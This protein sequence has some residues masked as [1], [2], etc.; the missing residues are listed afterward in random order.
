MKS[1]SLAWL[2]GATSRSGGLLLILGGSVARYQST[3]H[4]CAIWPPFSSPHPGPLPDDSSPPSLLWGNPLCG[5]HTHIHYVVHTAYIGRYRRA[6]QSSE[7]APCVALGALAAGLL[8][9]AR[10]DRDG[11]DGRCLAGTRS[12]LAEA[13]HLGTWALSDHLF[14][15]P[16]TRISYR[17]WWRGVRGVAPA[18]GDSMWLSL[19]RIL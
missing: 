17:S 3:Y 8:G 11:W 15:S 12:P 5:L 16:K 6:G 4:P 13:K 7:V 9:W 19:W 2:P 14:H 10:V 18:N 1:P